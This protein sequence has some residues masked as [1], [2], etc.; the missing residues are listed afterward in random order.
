MVFVA[1]TLMAAEEETP[2]TIGAGQITFRG[3][4]EAGLYF[5]VASLTEESFNLLTTEELLPTGEGVDIGRWT[6]R[7]DNPPTTQ[8]KYTVQY[9]YE[10]IKNTNEE[11]ADQIAFVVLEREE[12]ETVRT[13]KLSGDETEVSVS[14]SDSLSTISRIFSARL[15][16]AGFETALEAAASADYITFITVSLETD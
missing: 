7:V 3:F 16:D 13:P 11:I 9:E 15:T 2:Q 12:T 6:L 8:T 14:A 4:I 10:P 5:S 1:T